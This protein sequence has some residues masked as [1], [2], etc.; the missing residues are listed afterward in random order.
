MKKSKRLPAGFWRRLEDGTWG[1]SS[2]SRHLTK[3]DF[4]EVRARNGAKTIQEIWGL[5]QDHG[6]HKQA[7][8]EIVPSH[9]PGTQS[10]P[11]D[12]GL[13]IFVDPIDVIDPQMDADMAWVLGIDR[14][15][16]E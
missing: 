3:G 15:S 11:W 10:S 1:V 9:S 16:Q 13:A 5:A 6:M 14:S 8:Y 4:V 2:W 12:D 7:F